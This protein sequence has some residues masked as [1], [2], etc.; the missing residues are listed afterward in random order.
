MPKKKNDLFDSIDDLFNTLNSEETAKAITDTVTNV[1]SEIKHSINESLKKN[2]YDNFG[3]LINANIGSSK[4]H[5][6]P[7]A[8]RA[9]QTRRNFESRYDY[10]MDALM[11]VHYD[12]KYRGYFKEGHQEA[13]HTYLILAENYKT[14]LDAL[15]LRLRNEIRDL[16]AAMR[17]QKKDAWNEGYLNGLEYIG[18]SLKNSKV[19]MM[20][21]IQMELSVH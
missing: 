6:R 19:Y 7:Q 15:N 5:R 18:R 4:E 1:G 17:K 9:Y 20:N 2:G 12:L 14:N 13:I 8:R 10:F 11:S 16:K 3:E 21:K